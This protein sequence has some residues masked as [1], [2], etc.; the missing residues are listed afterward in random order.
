[1]N[2][3]RRHDQVISNYINKCQQNLKERSISPFT[4]QTKQPLHLTVSQ[5]IRG[6]QL[7]ASNLRNTFERVEA[8]LLLPYLDTNSIDNSNGQDNLKAKSYLWIEFEQTPELMQLRKNI[9]NELKQYNIPIDDNFDANY[10][11]HMTIGTDIVDTPDETVTSNPGFS[12]LLFRN[13]R[14]S[15]I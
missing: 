10:T 14:V 6:S 8:S 7:L 5:A 15:V 11:P 1:M 2:L 13:L 3:D 12:A 4:P 9:Q